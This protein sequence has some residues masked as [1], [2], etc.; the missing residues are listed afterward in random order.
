MSRTHRRPKDSEEL[1]KREA[2]GLWMAQHLA[3]KIAEST[4]KISIEVIWKLHKVFQETANP[5]IAGR[6]RTTGEDIKKLK[7]ITPP[8]GS[9]VHEEMF[10]FWRNF[11]VQVSKISVVSRK[12]LS[13]TALRKYNNEVIDL[14]TWVQYEVARI[15]PFCEGNGRMARLMTNL[16]LRRYN[17]LPSDIKYQGENREKYL[18]ALCKIDQEGDYR[19]LRGL[20]IKGMA[21]SYEKLIKEKE[22]VVRNAKK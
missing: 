8:F 21:G 20:I 11:D 7:C 3:N 13:K 5:T 19:P 22:R 10:M 1:Q 12:N 16:V 15:H 17:L 2:G 18:D 9:K 4:E 14:A 6:F